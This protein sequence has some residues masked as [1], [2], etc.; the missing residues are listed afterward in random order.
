M[1]GFQRFGS[2][3]IHPDRRELR[4]DGK[5]L[6][7]GSRAMD[8]LLLLVQH[9]DR[10]VTKDEL[11]ERVWPGLVVEENNLQVHVS[12]LRKLLGSQAIATVPGLGYRF[13]LEPSTGPAE[14]APARPADE[15]PAEGHHV[16]VADDNKVNRLLLARS[17]ELMGHRVSTA[18]NG[19]QALERVRAGGFDLLLLDL[20]MPELDGFALLETLH[21]DPELRELP[22]II[23][24]SVEGVGPVARCIE[25]GADD[26]LHKPVNPTLLKARVAASLERRRARQEQRA[27]VARLRAQ[28]PATPA[29]AAAAAP[30]AEAPR[31]TTAT[32][33]ALRLPDLA[34]A[35]DAA[36][37]LELL[38]AC[39]TLLHDA[40]NSHGGQLVGEP[41][42]GLVAVFGHRATQADAGPMEA[43]RTALEMLEMLDMLN[44]E[45]GALGQPA[46][47]CAIG[48]AAGEVLVGPSG[49]RWVCIGE[50]VQR[51]GTL[52]TLAEAAG[53]AANGEHTVLLD[54]AVH[55]A[56]AGRV[57][58]EA[59]KPGSVAVPKG[60]VH[61]LRS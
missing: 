42:D 38:D 2:V 57:A 54:E 28:L 14:P 40:V 16:L 31:R 46:A 60:G 10:L 3:E 6:T 4:M 43:V 58:C 20:E 34:A 23:T 7:P 30:A 51:A 13:A 59:V 24:S 48:L 25:L 9:R 56:V 41:G 61:A 18:E 22:V 37:S 47:R 29:R 15:A 50:P 5:T 32:V 52:Q 36:A 53:R 35:D 12:A 44:A 33:L 27:L 45:R 11:L 39:R 17:L 49:A 1:S 19:R 21:A 26:F 55:A 8:V